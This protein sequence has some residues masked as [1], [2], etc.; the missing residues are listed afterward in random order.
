M[1][2]KCKYKRGDDICRG[3]PVLKRLQVYADIQDHAQI[4]E[5]SPVQQLAKSISN[6]GGYFVGC[7]GWRLGEKKHRFRPLN[8]NVDIQLFEDLLA[9]KV[10]I[11]FKIK[12]HLKV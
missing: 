8:E 7:S 3:L 9:G 5:N 6:G 11:Q 12:L 4:D 10:S 1:K 2:V